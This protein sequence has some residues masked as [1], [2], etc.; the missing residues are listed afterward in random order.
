M[1]NGAPFPCTIT[2]RTARTTT[3]IPDKT[4]AKRRDRRS[5]GST[6][7]NRR[8]WSLPSE[9]PSCDSGGD[10]IAA[11][12]FGLVERRV[13][14]PDDIVDGISRVCCRNADAECDRSGQVG[15][16]DRGGEALPNV[17]GRDRASVQRLF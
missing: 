14:L 12:C 15:K 17:L 1:A 13:G 8:V 16:G 5:R 4:S 10:L 3:Q 9:D 6:L 2:E 11:G 7:S